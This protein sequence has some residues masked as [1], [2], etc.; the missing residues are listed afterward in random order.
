MAGENNNNNKNF[1]INAYQKNRKQNSQPKVAEVK[2]PSFK[3]L[4]VDK[5]EVKQRVKPKVKSPA[6]PSFSPTIS[7]RRLSALFLTLSGVEK[8]SGVIKAFTEDELF[9]IMDEILNIELISPY[10]LEVV[11]K[12]FGS[13]GIA[14]EELERCRGGKEFA[15]ALLGE[16]FGLSKGSE[17]F[18]ELVNRAGDKK[19]AFI[20]ELS[21]E[22]IG[23]LLSEEPDYI[24]SM[25]LSMIKPE[26]AAKVISKLPPAQAIP[27][28]KQMSGKLEINS[29]AFLVVIDKL[30]ERANGMLKR[31]SLKISGKSRLLEIIKSSSPDNSKALIETIEL[32]D[33]HLAG[34]LRESIFSFNDIVNIPRKEFEK[35]LSMFKEK[36]IA[37]LL[38]GANEAIRTIF[39]TCVTKKRKN[40]IEEEIKYLGKVKKSDVDRRRKEFILQLLE[41]EE[42]GEIILRPDNEIYVE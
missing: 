35:I 22:Q 17:L 13:L 5:S 1:F 10:E 31:D 16:A 18:I 33:P 32:N 4:V 7:K 42:K 36:E 19:L 24:K 41:L 12:N 26:K 38:K 28:I 34:E 20:D 23:E 2:A 40:I 25:I 8:A 15:R 21:S 14:K 3:K 30:K 11:E 9:K 6:A 37:F 27:V 29:D 39:F